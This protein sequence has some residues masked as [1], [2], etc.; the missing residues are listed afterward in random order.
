M[1]LVIDRPICKLLG[2]TPN[3]ELHVYTDGRRIVVEPLP[4]DPATLA[5]RERAN[6]ERRMATVLAT[7]ASDAATHAVDA[8]THAVDAA[9]PPVACSIDERS[10]HA[11]QLDARRVIERML[12][13]G[14]LTNTDFARFHH[15]FGRVF[16]YRGWVITGG[17]FSASEAELLAMRRIEVALQRREAGMEWSQAIDEALTRYPLAAPADPETAA[18]VGNARISPAVGE[19]TADDVITA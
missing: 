8:A 18:G 11:V 3:T 12:D 9:L 10:D 17:H 6:E 4:P 16:A 15:R 13:L 2:I 7:R 19:P 1:A 14:G 5:A